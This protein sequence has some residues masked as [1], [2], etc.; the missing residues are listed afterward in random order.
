[1]RNISPP[2]VE[3]FFSHAQ[4]WDLRGQFL[5]SP[6]EKYPSPG[7]FKSLLFLCYI[8]KMAK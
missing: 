1:M 8:L 3:I 6:T 5:P 7:E 2:G 4:V